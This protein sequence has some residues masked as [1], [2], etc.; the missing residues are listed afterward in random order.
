MVSALARSSGGYRYGL[1]RY[2]IRAARRDLVMRRPRNA[3][4]DVTVDKVAVDICVQVTRRIRQRDVGNP[5]FVIKRLG[6][7]SSRCCCLGRTG[8]ALINRGR[9]EFI[10]VRV[11]CAWQPAPCCGGRG[12]PYQK[13][14]VIR[15]S[16]DPVWFAAGSSLSVPA[17]RPRCGPLS[18][19]VC[20]TTKCLGSYDL[21]ET[22]KPH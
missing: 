4:G 1:A 14:C 12:H 5:D 8:C 19:P 15:C 3:C 9:I 22:A 7:V 11:W 21:P 18:Q 6:D 20:Q 2:F 16:Y 17:Q 13:T 10:D